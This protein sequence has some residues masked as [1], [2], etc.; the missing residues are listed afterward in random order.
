VP[1]RED[2]EVQI[3]IAELQADIQ[4]YLTIGFGFFAV[5]ITIIV[6]LIQVIFSVPS[7]QT[8][9][10]LLLSLL[11]I[12]GELV[13]ARYTMIFAEKADAARKELK[14]LRKRYTW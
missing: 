2:I 13:T 11:C 14:K 8:F 6:G 9:E 7:E 1:Y 5:G 3:R 10:K 12:V 4:T